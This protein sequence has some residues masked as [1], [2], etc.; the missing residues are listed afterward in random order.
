MFTQCLFLRF[1][2]D[3]PRI[4]IILDIV[5]IPY[6]HYFR[7]LLNYLLLINFIINLR[8]PSTYEL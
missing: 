2:L 4:A 7:N 5:Q 3:I 8:A 1:A 6:F